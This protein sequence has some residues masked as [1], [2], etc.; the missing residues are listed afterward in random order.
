MPKTLRSQ[1]I[2]AIYL[3]DNGEWHR[4][5]NLSGRILATYPLYVVAYNLAARAYLGLGELGTAAQLL[6]RILSADPEN[7]EAYMSLGLIYHTNGAYP[8]AESCLLRAYELAPGDVRVRQALGQLYYKPVDDIPDGYPLS[9]FALARIYKREQMFIPA[10]AELEQLHK[11]L[12]NRPDIAMVL[13][14]TY[15]LDGQ[16]DAAIRVASE[17]LSA[18]PWCMKA[19]LLLGKLWLNTEHD[20]YARSCLNLAQALDPENRWAQA[21]LGKGSPLPARIA[22]LSWDDVD[23][24]FEREQ[25]YLIEID[26][27]A[28][29]DEIN[30]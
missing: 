10:L 30:L 28:E 5:A 25:G 13:S 16:T 22:T 14:E 12:P 7:A 15:W 26:R 23:T 6:Q 21:L 18:Y 2:L 4:A 17:L 1:V 24:S 27:D 20:E 29:Q 9:R 19:N 11:Q 8:R 3:L